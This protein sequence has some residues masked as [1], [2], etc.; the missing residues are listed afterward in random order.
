[1][2]VANTRA[3]L[4]DALDEACPARRSRAHPGGAARRAPRAAAPGA[5]AGRAGW[6]GRGL[7]LREPAPVRAERGPRQVPAD[8]GRGPGRLRCRGRGPDARA[9]RP[10]DV[11]ASAARQ[12]RSPGQPGK[13]SK[14]E[15]RPGFFHG[16][17]TVVLKLLQPG[18]PGHRRLRTEEQPLVLVRRMSADFNS[19]SRSRR[20]RRCGPPTGSPRRA[21]TS[22]CPARSGRRRPC[23]TGRS[24]WARRRPQAARAPSPPPRGAVLG[25]PVADDTGR[26]LP[27]GTSPR[28]DHLALVD[29]RSYPRPGDDLDFRGTAVLAMAA[30][31]GTTRLI[32][33]VMVNFFHCDDPNPSDVRSD[34]Q[35]EKGSSDFGAEPHAADALHRKHQHGARRVRRGHDRRALAVGEGAGPDGR[36]DSRPAA[37]A[38]RPVHCRQGVGRS[39]FP[40]SG[41]GRAWL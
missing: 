8:P 35:N 9:F 41:G 36:R 27:A 23:C 3:E 33:N 4:A 5:R 38:A 14:G 30:R 17:L 16:V 29:E 37:R 6:H 32:D 1:M 7:D 11:P 20:S 12:G 21:G 26:S 24:P 22:T 40:A 18:P 15:S 31:V 39:R 2:I 34:G 25:D 13:S 10:G 28:V 19:A